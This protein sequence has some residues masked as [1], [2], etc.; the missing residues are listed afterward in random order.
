LDIDGNE[1]LKENQRKLRK[2]AINGA[3]KV[4]T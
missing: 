4:N 1:Y 3:R 2:T